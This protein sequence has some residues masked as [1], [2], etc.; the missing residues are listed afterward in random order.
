VIHPESALRVLI[1]PDKFK[2]TLTA[3]EAAAAIALGVTAECPHAVITCM[4]FADGGEGTVEAVVAA[5]GRRRTTRVTGPLGHEVDAFWSVVGTTAVVEMAQSSGLQLVDPSPVTAR[6]AHTEGLGELIRV[7]LDE[8]ISRIV[9]GVG[10]SASTD[11]AMGALWTLGAVF[12]DE[13]GSPLRGS[14]EALRQVADID[15]SG[16]DPRLRGVDLILCSD[17]ANPFAGVE[18]AAAVFGPQ[19]GADPATIADLDLGLRLYAAALAR[20]TGV[21]PI[22]DGWGGSGGGFAGGMRAAC[23]AQAAD[24]VDVVA[25]LVGLDAAL[26]S[27][28]F[29]IVGEGSIDLQ[30][31]MGKTPVGVARHARALGVPAAAVVG[32]NLLPTDHLLAENIVAISAATDS[33][34]TLADA[35]RDPARWT[36]AA[37]R[38]LVTRLRSRPLTDWSPSATDQ[39]VS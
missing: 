33:A 14:G 39:W 9:I 27:Q 21:D 23:G 29:V 5:G 16:L 15:L 18:G 1:A 11:G 17:V 6:Q 8:K 28:D 7:A 10:G 36:T 37:T 30:S 32:R 13:H 26:A 31:A 22:D 35:L 2:G 12:L 24:G 3:R 25:E 20:A 34:P 4:P 19:K 38:Q